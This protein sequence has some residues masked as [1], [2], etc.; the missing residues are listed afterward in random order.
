MKIR[1]LVDDDGRRMAKG[2]EADVPTDVARALLTAGDAEPVAQL[3][4]ER[5]EKRPHGPSHES[6]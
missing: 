3:P 2:A 4:T 6:R 5:N 1:I